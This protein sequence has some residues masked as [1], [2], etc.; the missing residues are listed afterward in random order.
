[1]K[2][3]HKSEAIIGFTGLGVVLG[4]GALAL[5]ERGRRIIHTI[6]E[7]FPSAPEKFA[8]WN[9][10]AQ[11]EL[12]R[13]QQTLDRIAQSLDFKSSDLEQPSESET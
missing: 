3:Q 11:R 2:N 10:T 7:N 4:L 8:S 5:T 9:E 13:I 1:M 12:N 6:A